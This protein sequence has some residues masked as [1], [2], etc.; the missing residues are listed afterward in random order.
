MRTV[1]RWIPVILLG[2]SGTSVAADMRVEESDARLQS[3]VVVRD[4]APV[5]GLKMSAAENEASVSIDGPTRPRSTR[6][7]STNAVQTAC[8]CNHEH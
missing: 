3:T 5:A 4:I 8:L 2:L 1:R 6:C 7:L